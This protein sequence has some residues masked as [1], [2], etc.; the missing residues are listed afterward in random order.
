VQSSHLLRGALQ[1]GVDA[2]LVTDSR[3]LDQS[4]SADDFAEHI[5]VS[6]EPIHTA[7]E[8]MESTTIA[9]FFAH[10]ITI[11]EE[12]RPP[13]LLWVH[14]R[15][16]TAP[17]DAPTAIRHQF[18]DEDDPV[19]EDFVEPPEQMFEHA[20]PDYLLTIAHAYAAQVAVLD[21]CLGVLLNCFESKRVEMLTVVTSPRGFPLGEHGRIGP[22]DHALYGELLHT[23]LFLRF[24]E[25][26][27]AS[28]RNQ[29]LVQPPDL[30]ATLCGWFDISSDA[31]R[32]WGQD[33]VSLLHNNDSAR[34]NVACA[35]GDNERAIRTPAWFMRMIGEALPKLFAKPD[36][37]NEVND[38]ADICPDVV[39]E[40]VRV[41]EEFESAVESNDATHITSLPPAL[42]QPHS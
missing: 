10:A 1:R 26:R 24:P 15:G 2:V 7:A 8:S 22:C 11:A 20:D 16:M 23:P 38:V 31:E 32:M 42:V 19:P 29:R 40:L 35:V 14:S 9:S 21:A 6:T 18:A 17:W 37:R 5:F 25:N 27:F 3:E 34:P 39:D 28:Y 4:S 36:D 33:L 30:F 13:F 12:L 41:V